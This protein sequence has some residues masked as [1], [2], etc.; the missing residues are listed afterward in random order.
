[1]NKLNFE[2][3]LPVIL[4]VISFVFVV[5]FA[6]VFIALL[7]A[8][9]GVYYSFYTKQIVLGVSN[10]SILLLCVVLLVITMVNMVM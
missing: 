10:I 2:K 1:M 7:I 4:L 5:F 6:Q 3:F 8:G 9:V